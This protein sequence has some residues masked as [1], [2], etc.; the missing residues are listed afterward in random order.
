MDNNSSITGL[1][2]DNSGFYNNTLS[3]ASSFQDIHLVGSN[4]YQIN[5]NND[6]FFYNLIANSSN[7]NSITLNN[8]SVC[9]AMNLTSSTLYAL[10]F[11]NYSWVYDNTLNNSHYDTLKLSNSGF[12]QNYF[13]GGGA[14]DLNLFDSGLYG[15]NVQNSNFTNIEITGLNLDYSNYTI[16]S[17]FGNLSA[18]I[19]KFGTIIYQFQF[20]F[21]GTDGAGNFGILNTQLYP[22]PNGFYI[23]KVIL[24]ANS[25]TVSNEGDACI[26]LGVSGNN[27][28]SGI[29]DT[30][31]LVSNMIRPQVF[32]ISNGKVT[33]SKATSSTILALSVS[34]TNGEWGYITGGQMLFEVT[35]KNINYSTSND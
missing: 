25:I 4:M 20:D 7:I 19:L 6:A 23:E 24:D 9:A 21:N 2:L 15:I 13:D 12:G 29:S 14:I 11:D 1:E 22:I 16:P 17:G 8:N 30:T 27:T 33:I 35:L 18:A 34:N 3:N 10:D 5:C 26:N 28:A 32:D 31:G